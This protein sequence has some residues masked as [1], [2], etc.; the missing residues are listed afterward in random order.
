MISTRF[1]VFFTFQKKL[2][3]VYL[4]LLGTTNLSGTERGSTN[5]PRELLRVGMIWGSLTGSLDRGMLL[6]F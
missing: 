4:P 5:T 1:I 6:S 2:I 3:L